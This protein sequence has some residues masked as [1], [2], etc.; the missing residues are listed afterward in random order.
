[1]ASA[2]FLEILRCRGVDQDAT[3]HAGMIVP[4]KG[5]NQVVL[6]TDEGVRPEDCGNVC[7]RVHGL[8]RLR[9]PDSVQAGQTL[10][11][12]RRE[13]QTPVNAELATNPRRPARVTTRRRGAASIIL[14][15]RRGRRRRISAT[16]SSTRVA[17]LRRS[18]RGDGD[19]G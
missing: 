17:A 4:F 14:R 18:A 19:C 16:C 11:R 12:V 9:L 7:F 10:Q 5:E 13:T 2:R 15:H 6:E 3:P 8:G 1:M